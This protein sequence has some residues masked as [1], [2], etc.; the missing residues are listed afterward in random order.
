MFDK[1][2]PKAAKSSHT[3]AGGV[4]F[5]GY[6]RGKW[7]LHVGGGCVDI[8]R[9]VLPIGCNCDHEGA[10][11]A[12]WS[13]PRTCRGGFGTPVA[14]G[15]DNVYISQVLRFVKGARDARGMLVAQR[16]GCP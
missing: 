11:A 4:V 3:V 8:P 2:Q 16:H 5:R 12:F 14:F 15:N 10:F 6:A 13:T 9:V 1:E 7:V